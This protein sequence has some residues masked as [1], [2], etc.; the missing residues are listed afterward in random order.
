MVTHVEADDM[1]ANQLTFAAPA[2]AAASVVGASSE[3]LLSSRLGSCA[4]AQLYPHWGRRG[5]AFDD[6]DTLAKTTEGNS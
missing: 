6:S 4:P 3:I 1:L 2:E 5:R